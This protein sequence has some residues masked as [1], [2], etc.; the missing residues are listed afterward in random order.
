MLGAQD[1]P[2]ETY[3]GERPEH[4]AMDLT[5][6]LNWMSAVASFLA[7]AS[8][9]R[10]AAVSLPKEITSG[11]GG[12]GGTAQVLGDALR[13]QSRLSAWGAACAAVAVL[14]QGAVLLLSD[15]ADRMV[16]I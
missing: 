13:R 1:Q 2:G 7:A 14:I 6:V 9:F 12:V 16:S 4:N 15:A 5:S 8:W 10:S 3:A 11:F